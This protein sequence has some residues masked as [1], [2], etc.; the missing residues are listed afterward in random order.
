MERLQLLASIISMQIE[1]AHLR[2]ESETINEVDEARLSPL[3]HMHINMLG[4]YKF[5]LAEQ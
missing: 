1:L 3:R 4:H 2:N 5:T